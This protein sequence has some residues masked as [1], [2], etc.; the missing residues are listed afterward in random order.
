MSQMNKYVFGI[1]YITFEDSTKE[2][3][4]L[5]DAT[6]GILNLEFSVAE[7]RGGTN[8]DIRKTAVHSRK[9]SVTIESGLA[10]FKLVQ[11][12][13]GGTITSQATSAASVTTGTAT[14][15]NT[16]YGTTASII[17]A[18][19]STVITSTAQITTNDY[20]I[21]ATSWN[22]IE[23]TRTKDGKVFGPYTLTLGNSITLTGEGIAFYTVTGANSSAVNSLTATE[24]AVVN[25]RETINSINAILDFDSNKPTTLSA[26]MEVSFDGYRTIIQIP[27]VQPKGTVQSL[28]S[29]EFSI[30]NMEMPIY[31][32]QDLG[33][34][35]RMLRVG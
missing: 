12:L 10:D 28:S 27:N 32:S 33:R 29:T 14:G 34:L 20:Y 6:K 21:K 16:L 31:N 13:T 15:M 30:Q 7:K 17:T 2:I 5:D 3:Y 26:R 1:D 24:K 19:T 4:G 23:V 25:V 8:N 22:V 11:L 9:G 35:A 18:F